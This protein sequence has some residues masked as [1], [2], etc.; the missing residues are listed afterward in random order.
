VLKKVLG[1]FFTDTDELGRAMVEV[2]AEGWPRRVLEMRDIVA[3][4]RG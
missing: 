1:N 3:A 2:S 4:G